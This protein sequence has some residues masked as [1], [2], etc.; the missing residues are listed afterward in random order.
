MITDEFKVAAVCLPKVYMRIMIYKEQR[1][2]KDFASILE[3]TDY[4][5]WFKI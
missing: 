3:T 1:E 2:G 5:M 4:N